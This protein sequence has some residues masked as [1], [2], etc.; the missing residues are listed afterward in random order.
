MF[1]KVSQ[2]LLTYGFL[3]IFCPPYLGP[4]LFCLRCLEFGG[5]KCVEDAE[6]AGWVGWSCSVVV[7][8]YV[9]SWAVFASSGNWHCL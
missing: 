1:F 6:P 4:S 3:Q 5:K 7:A 8:I 9:F 2:L